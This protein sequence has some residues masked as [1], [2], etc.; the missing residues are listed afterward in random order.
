MAG[1]KGAD[2]QVVKDAEA[3]A[4]FAAKWVT[5]TALETPGTVTISLSGGSTPKRLYEL[6][7]TT[8]LI[9]FP[10]NRV[11]WFWGDERYVGPEDEKSNYHM[12]NLA[13]LSKAPIPPGHVHRVLTESETVEIAAD[14]YQSNLQRHYGAR[15]LDPVRPLFDIMLLGL[16]EDA[17]TASLFPGNKALKEREAWVVSVPDGTPPPRITLTFPALNSSRHTV[18]LVAGEA[19]RTPLE[20]VWKGD[21][22]APS[23]H[24][25]PTGQLHLF[26]DEA[27]IATLSPMGEGGARRVATGG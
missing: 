14:R 2:R 10:W 6:L 3:L 18:F 17:H 24:I 4:V 15:V 12:T 7:A 1:L 16:G 21:P 20:R 27:A 19:K 5:A 26:V 9:D 13:M 25:A 8:H 11:H 23:A 22:S